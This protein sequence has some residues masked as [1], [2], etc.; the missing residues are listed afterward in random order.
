MCNIFG[1]TLVCTNGTLI[2]SFRS[3]VTLSAE[4]RGKNLERCVSEEVKNNMEG[5]LW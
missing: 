5:S 4:L 2:Y 1:V 3:G